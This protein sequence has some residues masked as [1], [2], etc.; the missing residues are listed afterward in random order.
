MFGVP[1][2]AEKSSISLLSRNPAPPTTAPEPKS[3]F[4]V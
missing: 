4:R 3:S 2:L 1:G